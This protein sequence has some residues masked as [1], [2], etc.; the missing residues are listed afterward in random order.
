MQAELIPQDSNRHLI[1]P[2]FI[3]AIFIQVCFGTASA[4]ECT[5]HSPRRDEES[6]SESAKIQK[7]GCVIPAAAARNF[8]R[9]N[10]SFAW[11][12]RS[13]L[14]CDVMQIVQT[15]RRYA[16]SPVGKVKRDRFG[17]DANP[18]I[19]IAAVRAKFSVS[20]EQSPSGA[21]RKMVRIPSHRSGQSTRASL[22]SISM[23]PGEDNDPICASRGQRVTIFAWQSRSMRVA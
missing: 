4:Q 10:L 20:K 1:Q 16:R 23:L 6:G 7:P 17:L 11:P 12:I 8:P 18:P 2:R 3:D 14:G 21:Q 15:R 9:R 5:K 19:A 22:I 13:V